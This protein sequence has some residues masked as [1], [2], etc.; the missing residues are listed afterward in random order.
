MNLAE[1]NHKSYD[2]IQSFILSSNY[3]DVAFKS[4]SENESA[5][6]IHN[7]EFKLKHKID[8]LNEKFIFILKALLGRVV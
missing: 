2:S 4:N 3:D 7:S 1:L 5:F 8:V 6:K